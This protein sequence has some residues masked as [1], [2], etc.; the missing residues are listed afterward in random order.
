MYNKGEGY[1]NFRKKLTLWVSFLSFLF[2][3][4]CSQQIKYDILSVDEELREQSLK[5]W[6]IRNDTLYMDNQKIVQVYNVSNG[7][8]ALTDTR[9]LCDLFEAS[10]KEEVVYQNIDVEYY[11]TSKAIRTLIP[12][13]W[14]S[15]TPFEVK[16]EAPV[17]IKSFVVSA[18]DQVDD[19]LWNA[20]KNHKENVVEGNTPVIEQPLLIDDKVNDNIYGV[21]FIPFYERLN[22]VNNDVH[23]QVYNPII[24][25]DGVVNGVFV[26]TEKPYIHL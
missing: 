7:Y 4:G 14:E 21:L 18:K 23:Y 1:M 20:L 22:L 5:D 17:E 12:V 8:L 10:F 15:Q 6:E 9:E 19:S 26:V 2:I 11:T 16:I 24:N 13:S 3:T 25:H